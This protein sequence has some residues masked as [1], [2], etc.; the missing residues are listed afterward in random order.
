MQVVKGNGPC[1]AQR[2]AHR[3]TAHEDG[4]WVR[5]AAMAFAAKCAQ[6]RQAAG[7]A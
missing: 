5:E 1:N 2:I 4:A 3:R 7:D 6:D